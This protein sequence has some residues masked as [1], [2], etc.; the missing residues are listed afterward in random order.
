MSMAR[1]AVSLLLISILLGACAPSQKALDTS[2][3]EE[4]DPGARYLFYLH[5]K[6]IEDQGLP[7][8]SEEYGEYEYDAILRRFA[9][10]DL[11][12]I[13]EIREA[14][15]DV[16]AYGEKLIEQ[17]NTLMEAGVPAE[18]IT[19]VGAS[20]GAFIAVYAS[21]FLEESG[22]NYVFLG[23]CPADE[24]AFMMQERM[25]FHGNILSIY[26]AED[27]YSDP[28]QPLFIFSIGH[29]I[30]DYNE[31]V[32]DVGTEHGILYQPLDEWVLPTIEWAKR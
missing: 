22:I 23:G 18:K 1:F 25:Y 24:F 4:V 9:E 31:I 32:V 2:F 20:K 27:I 12:V 6:I 16:N 30:G 7:A 10:S 29:G 17:I 13:S 21:I 3:P 11:R 15:A 28:C 8:I 14:N 5:G 26:D 19:V